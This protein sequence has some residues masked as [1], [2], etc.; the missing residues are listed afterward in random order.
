MIASPIERSAP[1]RSTL[2]RN[3]SS[4]FA[5]AL[6]A[7]DANAA[8]ES[9]PER[10]AR[11][12]KLAYT[13][14]A[15]LG[16][17]GAR[18]DLREQGLAIADVAGRCFDTGLA[19][20]GHRM[21][22]EIVARYGG[23]RL[24]DVADD[25]REGERLGTVALARAFA[26][27][28]GTGDLGVEARYRSGDLVLHGPSPSVVSKVDGVAS[29][30]LGASSEDGPLVLLVDLDATDSGA[31]FDDVVVPTRA[32][33]ETPF[34]QLVWH[35]RPT[36][37]FLEASLHLGHASASLDAT[38]A[39]L[40]PSATLLGDLD[41]L[42]E[43]LAVAWATFDAIGGALPLEEHARH[44]P[45]L[46]LRREAS[47]LSRSAASL[48][49]AA[50]GGGHTDDDRASSRRLREVLAASER[51]LVASRW[52]GPASGSDRSAPREVT[53]HE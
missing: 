16:L 14:A 28:E 3:A 19:L 10:R 37:A 26:F 20:F 9:P 53:K 46:E 25:L 38:A 39:A 24:G 18:G 5:A 34:S 13:G 47:R 8:D 41:A 6:R 44:A 4:S 2:G 33:L 27:L 52:T 30:L 29:V 31:A 35:V 40:G 23:A 22:A 50:A 11:L 48:A 45:P 32:V 15:S 7:I 42:R 17:P 43:R 49:H 21:A 36:Y 51:A 1:P 12:R